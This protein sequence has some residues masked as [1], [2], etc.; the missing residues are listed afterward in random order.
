MNEELNNIVEIAIRTGIESSKTG[1]MDLINSIFAAVSVIISIIAIA[2]S[3][4]AVKR[5]EKKN[6]YTNCYNKLLADFFEVQLPKM[7]KNTIDSNSKIV[8]DDN[9][10]ILDKSIEEFRATILV[11]KYINN[12][13]YTSMDKNII[14]LDEKLTNICTTKKEYFENTYNSINKILTQM[15]EDIRTFLL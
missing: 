13:F 2:V 6:Y 3:I 1:S 15:Y 9:Y 10:K 4:W 5:G 11:F 7:I 14:E 12:D 8:N